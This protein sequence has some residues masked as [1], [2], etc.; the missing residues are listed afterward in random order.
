MPAAAPYFLDMA[1]F[2]QRLEVV[3][4][5]D[6]RSIFLNGHL[7][8]RYGC[9]DKGTERILVT[10]LSEVLALPDRQIAA[11]FQI[12]PVSLSRF[13]GLARSGGAA[14]FWLFA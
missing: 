13:R 5:D 10:Q 4:V 14:D 9:G 12:H 1:P 11:A 7:A 8:G 2:T 6:Q 3:D